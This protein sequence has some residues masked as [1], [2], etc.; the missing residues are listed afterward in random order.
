[1][2]LMTRINTD[3]MRKKIHI[4]VCSAWQPGL[5][6]NSCSC[7]SLFPFWNDTLWVC[8]VTSNWQVQQD[9]WR[10]GDQQDTHHLPLKQIYK[11]TTEITRFY[12]LITKSVTVMNTATIIIWLNGNVKIWQL[13]KLFKMHI[14]MQM[15]EWITN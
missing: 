7:R 1:M 8:V 3:D 9:Y 6:W 5:Y 15:T 12:I 2:T 4:Q 10:T 14:N 11:H 13:H